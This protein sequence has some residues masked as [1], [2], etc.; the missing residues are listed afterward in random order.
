[1]I[2]KLI[3][4]YSLPVFPFKSS[5]KLNRLCHLKFPFLVNKVTGLTS[6]RV[7]SKC[8]IIMDKSTQLSGD[9]EVILVFKDGVGGEVDLCAL[10][11]PEVSIV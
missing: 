7:F 5:I 1:M 10:E 11:E 3:I 8:P 6:V 4:Q 9:S 2:S